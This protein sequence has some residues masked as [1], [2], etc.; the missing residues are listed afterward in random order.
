MGLIQFGL[1]CLV[2][3][4]IETIIKYLKA[5]KGKL[6]EKAEAK[7]RKTLQE[8]EIYEKLKKKFEK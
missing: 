6:H 1:G 8:K 4:F 5:T 7:N 3:Y 2:G